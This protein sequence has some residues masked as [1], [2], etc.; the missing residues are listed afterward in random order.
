M[1]PHL[2][3]PICFLAGSRPYLF[4]R[5]LLN[6]ARDPSSLPGEHVATDVTNRTSA[7]PADKNAAQPADKNAAQHAD[8]N[9]AHPADRNAA[10]DFLYS[11]INYER[12]A[13]VP[14]NLEA[15]KLDRM[16][17][18]LARVGD[19][20]LALKAVHIAGTKGKGS[21]AAMIAAALQAA[22]YKTAL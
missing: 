22:G 18:L 6:L 16:R 19:P 14:Y 20:H 17:Q 2:D 4:A 12:L 5:P 1:F 10:L 3:G 21:T 9:A 13:H 15:F 7:H 11:R 8:K